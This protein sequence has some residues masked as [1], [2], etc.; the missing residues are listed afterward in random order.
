MARAAT[1][2]P[3]APAEGE[4]GART[5]STELTARLRQAILSGELA[6]GSKLKLE[7]LRERLG[8]TLSRSPLREALS[9]L[10]AEGLVRIEDQRGY[11]VAPVSEANLREIAR[12]RIHLETLA[13]RESIAQGDAQWAQAIDEA[14]RALA[15]APRNESSR[16]APTA[17]ETAHRRFHFALLGACGMP[18]LL[19]YCDSLHDQNDRYR[20]LF[21]RRHPFDRNVHGEHQAIVEATLERQADLAC[22]LLAQ[23]IDR[24]THNICAALAGLN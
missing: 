3:A 2:S 5:L 15:G 18:L 19:Q 11:R 4:E 14:L 22:A 9:R 21:L 20:R 12:L 8:L 24:T 17:W 16:Q 6:P 7:M 23:H 1:A 13:L 10:G